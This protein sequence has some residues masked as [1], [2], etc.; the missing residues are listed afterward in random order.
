MLPTPATGRCDSRKALTGCAERASAA[1][2]TA[3]VNASSSGSGPIA[4]RVGNER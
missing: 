1:A 4:A 3:T 2:K